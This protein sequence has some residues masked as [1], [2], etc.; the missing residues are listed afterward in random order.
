MPENIAF[1]YGLCYTGVM[2]Y[3]PYKLPSVFTVEKLVTVHYFE[4]SKNFHY[5]PEAHD[6]WEFHYV[7]KGSAISISDGERILLNHGD[8][9]FHKPM[10]QH[11]ILTDGAVAPNVCVVSFYCKPKEMPFLEKRRLHLNAEERGVIKKFL[12]EAGAAFHLSHS[13]PSAHGLT[14]RENS[15]EGAA[16]MMKIHLEELLLLLLRGFSAPRLKPTAFS[17][18]ESFD[19][20]LVA[21]MIG[22]M[23]QNITKSLTISDFCRQFSYGKTHLCT[24]FSSVTGKTINTYFTGM[25]ISAAKRLI[26]EQNQSR[27]LFSRISEL[28]G[29]SSPSYFYSTFKR[30]TNMTPSEY[31]RSVHQYDFEEK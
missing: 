16:Q 18:S 31:F 30:Y 1:R 22:F 6:F 15:P 25:K 28:L 17:I 12:T 13:D 27:E 5:P 20:P 24:R 7:D 10:S 8:I 23:Q 4:L 11:Q 3:L 29:F 2:K 19:D 21:E 9:L 26:R 14:L